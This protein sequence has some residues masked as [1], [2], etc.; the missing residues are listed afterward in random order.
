MSQALLF[1]EGCFPFFHQRQ[2]HDG[3]HSAVNSGTVTPVPVDSPEAPILDPRMLDRR[4]GRKLLRGPSAWQLD[5]AL[6]R[7][8]YLSEFFNAFNLPYLCK[9]AWNQLYQIVWR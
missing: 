9:L 5:L 7:Q 6:S 1:F 4:R 8:F 3:T 2:P